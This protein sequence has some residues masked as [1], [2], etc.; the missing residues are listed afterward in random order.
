MTADPRDLR[1]AELERLLNA[2]LARIVELEAEV[3]E[4]KARLDQNS[5]NSSRPP[6]SD[7]P[8]VARAV[9]KRPTGR[10]PGGQPGHERSE[11]ELLPVEAV[12]AVVALIPERCDQCNSSRLRP[13]KAAPTRHQQTEIPAFKSLHTEYQCGS[14]ICLDCGALV[15]AELPP[16]AEAVFGPRLTAT[17]GALMGQFR[18]SKR[19]TQAALRDLTGVKI[20]L[21]MLPK[22]GAE[23]AA[24]LAQPAA[25]AEAYLREQDVVHADESGWF[26][27]KANGRNRRAWLWLFAAPLVAAFRI[28]FSRG[29]DVPKAVLGENFTG[30]L[31]TDRWAGYNWYDLGLRQ[32]CWSHL[33][34]DFQGFI[35]RGGIGG[36]LG[37]RLMK[38]RNRMFRWWHRVGDGRLSRD[39]FRQRMKSVRKTVRQLL[40]E[41]A[42]TAED[43]TAGMAREMLVLEEAFWTFV[44]TDNVEP[45]NNF[46]ER[47]VRPGV[48]YRKTSFGTQSNI[49]SRFVERAMTAV[50]TLNLQKRNVLDFLTQA[51]RAHRTGGPVP[52]LLPQD[53]GA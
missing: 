10:K 30:F 27:G 31:S 2:A 53:R 24:A 43:K 12:D 51:L 17:A 35:D 18:L 52:S 36:G 42:E 22:I 7:G 33:T 6:S 3:R 26:E 19:A 48:L 38:Q 5:R 37:T 9:K 44:D 20:S 34:R 16:E 21:G 14:A 4:L 47:C 23:I 46:A 1:I 11:R 28:A 29:S 32:L 8:Q 41:A 39:R 50:T 13:S 15:E 25:E 40:E 45:T 49:G